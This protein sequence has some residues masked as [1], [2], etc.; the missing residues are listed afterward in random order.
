MSDGLRIGDIESPFIRNA[1]KSCGLHLML[2]RTDEFNPYGLESKKEP[3][4]STM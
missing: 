4:S 3:E 2:F 1:P